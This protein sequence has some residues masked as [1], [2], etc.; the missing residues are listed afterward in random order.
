LKKGVQFKIERNQSLAEKKKGC[1]GQHFE[2]FVDSI[3]KS[4]PN[5]GF[6]WLKR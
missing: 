1:C 2:K 6:D 3:L 5:Q 4:L